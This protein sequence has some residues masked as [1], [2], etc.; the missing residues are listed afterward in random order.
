MPRAAQHPNPYVS[1]ELRGEFRSPKRG[2]T[3][4]IPAFWD[5][6]AR[7]KF[8]IAPTAVGRWD[9][10]LLSNISSLDRKVESFEATEA[11]TPGFVRVFNLRYFRYDQLSTPHLWM[12]DTCYK[13][14]TIPFD[15]FRQLVDIRAKQKFKSHAR[16]RARRRSQRRARAGRPRPHPARPLSGSRPPRRLHEQPGDHV[17]SD[18]RRGTAINSSSCFRNAANASVTSATSWRAMQR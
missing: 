9:F 15:T 10:R 12:G 7:F 8:R 2:T 13:F 14:A 17:R 18:P 4:V 11:R 3:H 5:G 1:V 6:G 16:P